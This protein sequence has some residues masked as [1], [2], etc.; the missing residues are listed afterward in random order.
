M[1]LSIQR[2]WKTN[3]VALVAF[4]Y[5]VPQVIQCIQAWGNGGQA[6]WKQ[7]LVGL[8]LAGGMA[9]AKDSTNHSTQAEVTV[10]T[11]DKQIADNKVAG[12]K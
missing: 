2:N 6:N 3:L 4:I 1:W 7:A 8:L 9:A 10:A 12:G 5:S 11:V